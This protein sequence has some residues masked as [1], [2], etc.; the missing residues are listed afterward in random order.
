MNFK[1]FLKPDWRKIIIFILIIIISNLPIIS[2]T[3]EKRICEPCSAEKP[4]CCSDSMILSIIFYPFVQYFSAGGRLSVNEYTYG[5]PLL[6]IF[7][8]ISF[9]FSMGYI[10]SFI[11]SI[12]LS[13]LNILYWYLPS[14]LIILIYNKIKK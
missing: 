10:F 7:R 5:V 1:Q 11:A 9:D 13:L 2:Y 6:E 8:S 12:F 14:C 4:N 3:T